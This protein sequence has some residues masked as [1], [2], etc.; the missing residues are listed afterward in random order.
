MTKKEYLEYAKQHN[1][2]WYKGKLVDRKT[3]PEGCTHTPICDSFEYSALKM[4][5][6]E[7]FKTR[8]Y[9]V[10]VGWYKLLNEY[11]P[12]FEK[13]GAKNIT[14]KEKFGT[15]RIESSN[16]N[17]FIRTLYKE[18]VEKSSAICEF[19]GN[20]G[21]L[22]KLPSGWYKT[23]CSECEHKINV[24]ILPTKRREVYCNEDGICVQHSKT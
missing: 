10:G 11:I 16:S 9:N 22:I 2:T 20:Q 5:F 15:L 6:D 21:S 17:E 24:G 3:V 8:K 13:A 19:C 7:Y 1:L 12:K 18:V 14:Y 23:L 4:L